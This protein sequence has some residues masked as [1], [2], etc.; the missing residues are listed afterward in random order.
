MASAYA[1]A[2]VI[3][4]RAGATTVAE[5]A[6]AGVPTIFIPYPFAADNHQ[7][8]N[9]REMTTAGAA[10]SFTQADLTAAVLAENIAALLDDEP[11]RVHMAGAMRALAKPR[12]AATVVDWCLAQVPA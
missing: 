2:D 12:A 4:A 10:L 8:R 3:V 11:R 9:A 6:I 5:I 7:E 1:K